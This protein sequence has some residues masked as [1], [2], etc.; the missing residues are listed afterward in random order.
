MARS[1][2]TSRRVE[3]RDRSI[4]LVEDNDDIRVTLEEILTQEGFQ[5]ATASNGLE[6]LDVLAHD[7][8]PCLIL[9]DLRMP[10]M[11]GLSF[12]LHQLRDPR[13]RHVPVVV[14]TAAN[15]DGREA[16]LLAACGHLRKPIDLDALLETAEE[17]CRGEP[18]AAH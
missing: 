2:E 3:S 6:A 13:I 4:L 7:P 10:V 17:A 11:D 12:R 15:E 16:A 1:R 14:L 18:V 5:V 8:L 9:L